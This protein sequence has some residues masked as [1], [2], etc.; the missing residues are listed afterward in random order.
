MFKFKLLVKSREGIVFNGEV[1]SLTS[2]NTKGRFDVL[3]Q[4]ANFISLIKNKLI[5]RDTQTN[6][7]ELPISNGLMRVKGD[8]VEVYLG[9]E[10]LAGVDNFESTN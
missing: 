5:I 8:N 1:I 3:P 2:F 10:A 4:H 6:I 9:I 7:K